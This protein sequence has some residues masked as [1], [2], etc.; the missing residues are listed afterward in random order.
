MGQMLKGVTTGK[1]QRPVSILLYGPG[2]VG[3]SS[4]GSQAPN[5]IFLGPENGTDE[6]DVARFND[7]TSY[8]KI[9]SALDELLKENHDFKTLVVDSVDWIEPLIY[10]KVAQKYRVDTIDKAAGG[11]GK[12]YTDAFNIWTG[13]VEKIEQ[14][15]IKKNMNIILIGHSEVVTFNDPQTNAP[16]DRY[17]LK[18]HKKT[19]AYLR[20]YVSAVLFA[21]YD[22]MVKE[23]GRNTKAFGSE[24]RFIHS[25]RRPGWDA[26]NRYGLPFRLDLDWHDFA[27]AVKRGQPES[28]E[29]VI[30]RIEGLLTVITDSELANL[31]RATVDEAGDDVRKLIKI[32]NRIAIRVEEKE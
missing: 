12:G 31:M 21:N 17:Q 10:R 30:Q 20:E 25:E 18:L 14:I 23:E 4:F 32:A 5:P 8:D 15:R 6:L 13:F 1:I 19:S 3:K 2:G 29:A 9:D 7:I 28:K 16:Y 22:T 24:L 11:F 27:A 26:K